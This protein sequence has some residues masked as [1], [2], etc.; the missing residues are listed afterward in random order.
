MSEFQAISEQQLYEQEVA[1]LKQQ[2]AANE[3]ADKTSTVCPS[4]VAAIIDAEGNDG[5]LMK[6]GVAKPNQFHSSA[7]GGGEG[8]CCV[9][10]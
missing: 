2:L 8:G 6:D 5:F 7:G 9:L 10:S 3:K 4:V 1:A